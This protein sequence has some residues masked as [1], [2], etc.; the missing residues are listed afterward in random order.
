MYCD[1]KVPAEPAENAS[2][3]HRRL[4]I[5]GQPSRAL[6][7]LAEKGVTELVAL[8]RAALAG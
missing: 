6:L 4:G 7:A 2:P 1:N 3:R 5:S 8:Q